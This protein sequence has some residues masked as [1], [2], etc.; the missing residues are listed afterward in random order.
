MKRMSSRG[1]LVALLAALAVLV[2]PAASLAAP[3]TDSKQNARIAK[4]SKSI[5]KLGGAVATIGASLK[6]VDNRLKT[7]EGAA[8]QIIDGLTQLKD[9]A[10]KLKD[11]LTAAAAGL[12]KLG[13]AYQAVEFGRAGIFAATGGTGTPTVVAGG[14]VT[15]ADIPDDGNSVTTGDEA[16]VAAPSSG[17][18]HTMAINLRAAIRSAES[19]GDSAAKTAGQAGGFVQ[20]S[21]LTTGASV[22]C[23]GSP[24]PGGIFGTQP[25][26]SIVTPSGTVTNLPLKNIP[27]GLLRTDTT[28]PTTSSTSLLPAACSFAAADNDVFRVHYSVNFVDIP[29]STTPGP[30]E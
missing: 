23:I 18:P 7:I 27:G 29:T 17:G 25:G 9:A 21:N 1:G 20:V 5:Q 30:T 16:I 10:T 15:S 3:N 13:D 14:T 28:A 6:S 4:H 8:P 22:A 26:D 2:V 11:G 19:D 12:T 24:A